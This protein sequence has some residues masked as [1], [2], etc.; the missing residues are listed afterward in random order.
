MTSANIAG[1]PADIAVDAG[2]GAVSAAALAF[3]AFAIADTWGGDHWL[4]G[5]AAGVVVCLLALTRRHHREWTAVAG[6]AVAAI[7]I[8]LAGVAHL[9]AEPSPALALGLSVLVGSAIRTLPVPWATAIVTGVL[10]TSNST[11]LAADDRSSRTNQPTTRTKIRYSSRNATP[12]DH[13]CTARG[14]R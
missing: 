3:T 1:G 2:L 13:A 8:L 7:A 4:F 10:G 9:P 11:S 12:H 5:C 6:L 14:A